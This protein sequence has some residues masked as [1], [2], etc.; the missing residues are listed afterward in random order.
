MRLKIVDGLDLSVG[1]NHAADIAL[2]GLG[3]AHLDGIVAARDNSGETATAAKKRSGITHQRRLLALG[4]VSIQWHTEKN[5]SFNVPLSGRWEAAQSVRGTYLFDAGETSL[6][7]NGKSGEFCGTG[8][9]CYL[10]NLVATEL[11]RSHNCHRQ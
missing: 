11:L 4:V 1:G 8:S 3:S 7:Q 6:G 10:E 9:K 5:V 2:L